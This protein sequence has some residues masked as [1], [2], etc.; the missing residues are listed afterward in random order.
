MTSDSFRAE[1]DA[2][3]QYVCAALQ[4]PLSRKWLKSD[5]EF[6]FSLRLLETPS[7]IGFEI[8][9]AE[10]FMN[11]HLITKLDEYSRPMLDVCQQ[12]FDQSKSEILAYSDLAKEK[13]SK[14]VFT[15]NNLSIE[16]I[17]VGLKWEEFHVEVTRPYLNY[18]ESM[19]ALR[20]ALIDLLAVILSLSNLT[21]GAD[22]AADLEWEEEGGESEIVCKRYE[23]SRFNRAL[24]LN[25][26]GFRCMACA[27]LLKEVYGEAGEKV[28]HVHHLVPVSLMGSSYKLNPIKDLV[29]LCPN[30]HNVAHTNNPPYTLQQ[31]REFLGKNENHPAGL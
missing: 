29:P 5:Y 24:C 9:V 8:L 21:P 11:W 23:R 2:Q 1:I 26:Y 16:S 6:D 4:V 15:V 3:L 10:D 30:C 19:I 7:P 20:I 28:I 22:N 31:L 14:Y 13:S 27:T 17:P 25:F 12:T 18:S